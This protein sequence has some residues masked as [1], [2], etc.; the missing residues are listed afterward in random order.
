MRD[1]ITQGVNGFKVPTGDIA[2]MVERVEA[3]LA[4]QTLASA[5]SA[6]AVQTASRLTWDQFASASTL[7]YES[8]IRQKA[9]ALRGGK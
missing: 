2:A 7:F 6:N 1:V 5:V 8:L 4:D 9:S 3:V